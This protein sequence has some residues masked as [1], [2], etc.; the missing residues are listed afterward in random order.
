MDEQTV[1]LP[2]CLDFLGNFKS[3]SQN[4]HHNSLYNNV[5][6]CFSLH[7][8]AV[9]PWENLH[10]ILKNYTYKTAPNFDIHLLLYRKNISQDQQNSTAKMTCTS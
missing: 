5:K 9:I 4:S 3:Q 10:L 1:S 2:N 8:I 6:Y 7:R